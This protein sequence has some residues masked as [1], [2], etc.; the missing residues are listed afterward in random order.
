MVELTRREREIAGLVAEG[1]SNRG[2]GARL[3]LSERTAEY[4]VEQIR[5]KLGFH[6]RTEIAAWVREQEQ[7]G[8]GRIRGGNLPVHLTRF[9]GREGELAKLRSL[10][11][12]TRLMTLTGPGGV[13]KT[14]LALKLA[15]G[16]P[17]PDGA[18]FVDLAGIGDADKVWETLAQGVEVPE[19]TWSSL[20][21]VVTSHMA[22]KSSLVLLDNCEHLLDSVAPMV[23]ELLGRC[24]RLRILTTS[25]EPLSVP[26]ELTWAVRPLPT[27]SVG[28]SEHVEQLEGNDAIRLFVDRACL[29][30]PSFGLNPINAAAVAEITRRLDGIP[31]AIELAAARIRTMGPTEIEERL[32]HRFRLLTG[33]GRTGLPRQK[34]LRTALDWSYVL[35]SPDEQTVFKRLGVFAESLSLRAGE[36]VCADQHLPSERIWD[37]LS[38]LVEKSMV[39]QEDTVD[40]SRY[41][42]LEMMRDFALD[43]ALNEPDLAAVRN[44]HARFYLELA[45]EAEPFLLGPSQREWLDRLKDDEA[46]LQAAHQW[47]RQQAPDLCLRLGVATR[48]LWV[49]TGRYSK[50]LQ[51]GRQALA[52]DDSPTS[53]RG[54]LLT[55]VAHLEV[56]TGD[57]ELA[58]QHVE[59]SVRILRNSEDLIGL[60]E[61]LAWSAAVQTVGYSNP[62]GAIPLAEE[63]VEV[64]RRA[65]DDRTL[66][67][68]LNDLGLAW[69]M[70][71]KADK[72]SDFLEEAV[73]CIRGS[74][75]G[76]ET[77]KVIESLAQAALES[78][79]ADQAAALWAES[80]ETSLISGPIANVAFCLNGFAQLASASDPGRAVRLAAGAAVVRHGE[81]WALG[82]LEQAMTEGWL[83]STKVSNP[84][85][86]TDAWRQGATMTL[87]ELVQYALA[88]PLL[89]GGRGKGHENEAHL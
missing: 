1:L 3:F 48:W 62:W 33:G 38:R 75:D 29:A 70:S 46:N 43:H 89:Q 24:E 12:K 49:R 55:S 9:I 74:G 79:R 40:G 57:Y 78:G 4:H 34:T 68:A 36:Y 42:L 41:Q 35:L 17:W 23:G 66:G 8:R 69:L 50:G 11:P 87:D 18:W 7:A 51:L 63:A 26:G 86:A 72:A 82:R 14:R 64:A 61:A 60:A 28:L 53:T 47:L 54:R 31:L 27:P 77:A 84:E 10:L 13:G 32:R 81:G 39:Q 5:N 59:D 37:L 56:F 45:E 88:E 16:L 80:L 22:T 20:P 2:I 21:E 25:R 65:G 83:A 76:F 15:S 30:R 58:H 44:R 19:W 6:S 71:G 73:D 67:S 85:I 52:A